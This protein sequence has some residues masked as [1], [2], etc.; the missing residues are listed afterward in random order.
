MSGPMPSRTVPP[1]HVTFR[2][3][4]SD[5]ANGPVSWLRAWAEMELDL[6]QWGLAEEV[7]GLLGAW[8]TPEVLR[9]LEQADPQRLLW[10][11]SL[12]V[13]FW[14]GQ[15]ADTLEALHPSLEM[16]ALADRLLIRQMEWETHIPALL[17]AIEGE[18]HGEA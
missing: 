11:Q 2:R 16:R 1:V 18:A 9:A 8:P 12:E 14:Y 10:L 7:A 6:L 5:P 17:A 13:C 4:L 15:G 3:T